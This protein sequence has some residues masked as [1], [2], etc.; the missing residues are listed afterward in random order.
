[1]VNFRLQGNQLVMDSELKVRFFD[2]PPDEVGTFELGPEHVSI[3]PIFSIPRSPAQ[4]CH[5]VCTCPL[6]T[7]T[8]LRGGT[9]SEKCFLALIYC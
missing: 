5:I 4:F 9:L 8:I 2:Y 1:V 7:S 6:P 3:T